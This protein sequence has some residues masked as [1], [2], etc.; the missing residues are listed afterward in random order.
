MIS[1]DSYPLMFQ[2]SLRDRNAAVDVY[3]YYAHSVNAHEVWHRLADHLA[4]VSRRAQ[5][6]LPGWKGAEEA[7][8]AG[9]LHDLGKYG[10]LFQARLGDEENRKPMAQSR[11][12]LRNTFVSLY[13]AYSGLMVRGTGWCNWSGDTKS[14]AQNATQAG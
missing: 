14:R 12:L 7:A 1:K 13:Y 5:E 9:L 3:Y 6:F 8:L 11:S 4:G 2:R 10:D